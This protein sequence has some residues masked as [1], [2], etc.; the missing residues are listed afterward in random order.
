MS[1]FK[2]P[3]KQSGNLILLLSIASFGREKEEKN[4]QTNKNKNTHTQQ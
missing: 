1:Q 2:R 4:K 3:V